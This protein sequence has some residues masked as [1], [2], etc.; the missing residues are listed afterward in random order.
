MDL[1]TMA[2]SPVN[3]KIKRIAI[4][5]RTLC[6]GKRGIETSGIQIYLIELLSHLQKLDKKNIYF[7]FETKVSQFRCISPKWNKILVPKWHLPAIVW[8]QIVFPFYLVKYKIDILWSPKFICPI[9]CTNKIKI[10]TTFHDL[11]FSLYSQT[12]QFR[13]ILQ[14]RYFTHMSI[15]KSTAI[16]AVSDFTKKE[17]EIYFKTLKT[18]IISIPNGK[19][20]WNPPDD[21]NANNRENYLFFPGNLEPRKNILMAIRALEILHSE[22]KPIE[23]QIASPAGWKNKELLDYIARSKIKSNIKLLGAFSH[24]DL[25]QKYLSCKALL[26]PSLYEGF[27]LP[28]LEALTLDCLVITSK[29]TV[30]QEIA[31]KSALYFDPLNSNDI[32]DKIRMVYSND[33]D[34][35]KYL[36]HKYTVLNKYSWESAARTILTIFES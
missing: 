26:Y 6:D 35:N 12:M 17:I 29:N 7:L 33:F 30:M 11:V 2:L 23:L 21:Y 31:D 5:I 22:G 27:G 1:F 36:K 20:E 18:P 19:P 14:S 9:W 15:K 25:K 10:Y 34:R 3:D 8:Q 28:V 13:D 24:N 16:F 32:A 4:D